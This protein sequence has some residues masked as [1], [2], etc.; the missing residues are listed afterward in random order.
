MI[1]IDQVGRFFM[2]TAIA[3]FLVQRLKELGL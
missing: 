2:A 3:L 1:D